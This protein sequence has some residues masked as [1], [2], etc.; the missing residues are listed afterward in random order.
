MFK[1]YYT[2]I[3]LPEKL[4]CILDDLDIELNNESSDDKEVL[5]IDEDTG[6]ISFNSIM[7]KGLPKIDKH[8][9]FINRDLLGNA[10]FDKVIEQFIANKM[11][12]RADACYQGVLI[13]NY[14]LKI[15]DRA[16]YGLYSDII[17]SQG[18]QFAYN[19][20]KIRNVSNLIFL[21][22]DRMNLMG[23]VSYP[24]D[25]DYG[26]SQDI[27]FTQFS[28]SFSDKVNESLLMKSLN[29]TFKECDFVVLSLDNKLKKIIIRHFWVLNSKI[30]WP[31]LFVFKQEGVLEKSSHSEATLVET[32]IDTT[33]EEDVADN[34][35]DIY[36]EKSAPKR[37][38]LLRRI[39]LASIEIK[40][41]NIVE[42]KAWPDEIESTFLRKLIEEI[43]PSIS[44]DSFNKEELDVL[45]GSLSDDDVIE[46][47]EKIRYTEMI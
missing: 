5:C 9:C 10:L 40:K 22:L 17:C 43:D 45:I 1:R 7:A 15:I 35:S 41:K 11:C 34:L 28:C 36:D 2:S 42:G 27:F 37:W 29:K 30:T 25:T 39:L 32:K 24:I 46:A 18:K 44:F 20:R 21:M 23:E 13:K 31:S 38:K 4:K 33:V 6:H 19:T 16:S 26:R 12:L 3:D 47:F 8:Q 14:T